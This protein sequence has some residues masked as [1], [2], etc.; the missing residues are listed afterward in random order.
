AAYGGTPDLAT[1]V[2][3]VSGSFTS[4]SAARRLIAQGGV[5]VNGERATDPAVLLPSPAEVR[6]KIGKKE[7]VI[8]ALR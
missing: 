3:R 8:V 6:L 7:F 5:E 1:L 2:S 4:K